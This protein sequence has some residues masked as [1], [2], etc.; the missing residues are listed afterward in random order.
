MKKASS[1][2]QDGPVLDGIRVTSRL[3]AGKLEETLMTRL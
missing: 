3:S 1:D 2:F